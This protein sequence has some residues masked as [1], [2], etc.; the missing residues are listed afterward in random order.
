MPP[1]SLSIALLFVLHAVSIS[2]AASPPPPPASAEC[3]YLNRYLGNSLL[4]SLLPSVGDTCVAAF[5]SVL[6]SGD[7]SAICIPE[8]QSFYALYS[9]CATSKASVFATSYCGHVNNSQCRVVTSSDYALVS[10]VYSSCGGNFT[11]CAPSCAAAIAALEAFSGC[12]RYSDLNGPK[13]LCGQDPVAPCQTILDSNVAP[14]SRECAY[15]NYYSDL[16]VSLFTPSLNEVCRA[17]MNNPSEAADAC[18]VPECQSLYDL[19]SECQG[20]RASEEF[21]SKQ[22]GRHANR[23]CFDV[24]SNYTV[25]ST[26]YT[27]CANS[28]HC[29]PSCLDVISALELYGGCCFA[30]V[31]NGPKA[32][33]GQ[34]PIS[35]C[36]VLFNSTNPTSRVPT[37]VPA[38]V[39]VDST[40]TDVS[41][42]ALSNGG[43]TATGPNVLLISLACAAVHACMY[44]CVSILMEQ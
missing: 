1:L 32:L 30:G 14:P 23:T 25:L 12:C 17:A 33:C 19:A 7:T 44:M 34:Q 39:S 15:F 8:C 28:T 3:A 24:L 10:R 5:N 43:P 20:V 38:S 31:L 4:P 16:R 22:C 37:S 6:L 42:S 29:S 41:T 11:Y 9:R 40:D 18:N 21:A 26:V 13:A 2:S 27:S 35:Y 36:S